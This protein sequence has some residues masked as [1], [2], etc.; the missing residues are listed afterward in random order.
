MRMRYER[1][2]FY[3]FIPPLEGLFSP[4][5]ASSSEN[6]NMIPS[7]ALMYVWELSNLVCMYVLQNLAYLDK[8]PKN[9]KKYHKQ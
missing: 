9:I 3:S 2:L 6:W 5:W 8:Y 1:D 7:M 4:E